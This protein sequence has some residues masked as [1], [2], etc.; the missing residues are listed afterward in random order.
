MGWISW[1]TFAAALLLGGI[2]HI[3]ATFIAALS[4]SGQAY[5]QLAEKLPAN[6]MTVLP[7]QTPGRQILPFL[8]PDM[9]YAM[10]RYDLSGGS[11]EVSASVLDAG[12]ALSLH[13]PDGRNL[14]VLP[15]QPGRRIDVSFVVVPTGP[16]APPPSRRDSAAD[17]LAQHRGG[18]DP[19]RADPRPRVDVRDRGRLADSTL[20]GGE[21]E[22]S[23]GSSRPQHPADLDR[24]AWA[25]FQED[26]HWPI[27]ECRPKPGAQRPERRSISR[28][29]SRC[30]S[31]TA[32]IPR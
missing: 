27:P 8:P 14:Y 11:V 1:R 2:V 21:I 9:L 28:S 25:A 10:C 3:S 18:R 17:R 24:V 7:L 30:R 15:G 12:W 13:T 26:A 4:S 29:G 20:H 32:R 22:P 6:T 23:R 31:T 19:A 5:R 16:D